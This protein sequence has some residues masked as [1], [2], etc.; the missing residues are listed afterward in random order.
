MKLVHTF[1][2]LALA[3]ALV[4][5]SFGAPMKEEEE[6]EEEIPLSK[7]VAPSTGFSY[8]RDQP[9]SL[10]GASRFLDEKKQQRGHKCSK[11]PKIC[12]LQGSPGP[13]CCNNKCVNLRTDHQH[14][15]KCGNKCKFTTACCRGECV[16]LSFDKRHC[17]RC[18]N[19]CKKGI[20]CIYG[21]C[22]YG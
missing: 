3:M 7:D 17:G 16:Y 21:L 19:R 20:Y 15:G 13:D 6:E 1:F 4:M 5:A 11:N 8:A 12:K 10:R 2:I 9:S 22:N 18:N 14:C